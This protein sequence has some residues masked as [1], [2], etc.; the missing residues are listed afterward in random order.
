[1]NIRLLLPLAAVLALSA[2]A[3]AP[4][5]L[6]GQFNPVAPREASAQPGALVRWGG[7]IIETRPG[8]DQTCFQMLA[9]PLAA[10]GRP[11]GGSNADANDGRFIAC[12]SGFY[13][14]AVF[15]PGREVTFIGT[16]SGF[17]NARIGEFD[18]RLPRV[19]A[20]VVYLWPIVREVQVIDPWG[21]RWGGPWGPWGPSPWWG[22]H[23]GW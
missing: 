12:R 18:Y 14:P 13:D 20:N 22:P 4:K 16:V 15:Q 17:E 8:Q 10:T 23:W 2:C 11:A 1:M 19:D 3:T 5:P 6:Q 7:T 21:P 9:R